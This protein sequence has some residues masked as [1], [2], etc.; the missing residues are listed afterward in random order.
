MTPVEGHKKGDI[1]Y[2]EYG[3]GAG[4]KMFLGSLVNS[5]DLD[6]RMIISIK[7]KLLP[8]SHF[9]YWPSYMKNSILISRK[10][11]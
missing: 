2:I 11:S 6:F 3:Y 1:V 8:E 7:A 5:I 4:R 9:G 10:M